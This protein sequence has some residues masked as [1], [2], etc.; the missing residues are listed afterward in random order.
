MATDALD[1][2]MPPLTAPTPSTKRPS[3]LVT[4][5]K[6]ASRLRWIDGRP[7]PDVI[8][9]YRLRILDRF[10]DERDA[11]GRFRYNLAL[12][13]RAKK[14]WKSADLVLAALFALV[15]NDSPGGNQCYLLANDEGQA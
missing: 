5:R 6:F 8:E 7:L 2:L 3:E 10:L 15:A 9:P 13:G 12:C 14:N 11:T 1:D 4:F